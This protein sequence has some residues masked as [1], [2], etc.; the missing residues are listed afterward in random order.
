MS[1]YD[2]YDPK[3]GGFRA[4]LANDQTALEGA[5]GDA[6]AP[7]GVALDANGLVVTLGDAAANTGIVGVLALPRDLNAGDVVDVMTDG[8][9][10][11]FGGVAG[12]EYFVDLTTGAISSNPDAG[13]A[14]GSGAG[15]KI[16]HTVEAGR[17]VV[18]LARTP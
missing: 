8:E 10:V 9:I 3:D 17:L 12:T 4:A 14:A 7:V 6:D 13:G 16:G 18:R 15:H 2:K 11:E 1:R 5:V